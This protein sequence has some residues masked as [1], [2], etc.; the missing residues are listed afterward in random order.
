MMTAFLRE[1]DL[2]PPATTTYLDIASR[3]GWF[4][5]EMGALGFQAQ[6]VDRDPS[7]IAIGVA[8]YGIPADRMV[9]SDCVRYLRSESRTFDVV[10][11]LSLLHDFLLGEGTVSAEELIRLID[12]H[13][14]RVLFLDTGECHEESFIES[15][16]GWTPDYIERWLRKHTTFTR[17]DRLG[18]DSD[19]G[20]GGIRY[21]RTLFACVR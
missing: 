7:A 17:I 8:A 15:L 10:S 4:V 16:R 11:C 13:T 12:E 2:L 18:K 5:A 3:L 14:G 21:G 20:P 6:G 1:E 9:R 19:R